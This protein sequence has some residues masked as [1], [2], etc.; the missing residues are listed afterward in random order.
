[1]REGDEWKTA[2]N[3][4]M[5]HYEYLVLRFRLTN[6]PAV[7]QGLVNAVLGDMRYCFVFVY[8]DDIF[9]FFP[10]SK[11]TPGTSDRSFNAFWKI[12]SL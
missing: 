1:M 9:I 12:N 2:L 4:P 8:L 6:A 7:F 3:T 11:D 5:G 10:L